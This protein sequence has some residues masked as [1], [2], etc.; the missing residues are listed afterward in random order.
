MQKKAGPVQAHN[1]LNPPDG[2]RT[3]NPKPTISAEFEDEGAGVNPSAAKLT[4]D[5]VD[6]TASAQS[7]TAKI[8]YTPSMPLIDGVHKVKLEI[9]DGAGN[10]SAATWSFTLDKRPPEVRI[11]STNW[12]SL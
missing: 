5:G 9:S 3:H 4:V 7:S 1:S 8:T 6:V 11:L 10:T 2:S 12:S